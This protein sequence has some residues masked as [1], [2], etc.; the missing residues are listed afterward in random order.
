MLVSHG[1]CKPF[2]GAA[3]YVTGSGLFNSLALLW[4]LLQSV[5]IMHNY[6]AQEMVDCVS[7]MSVH[8]NVVCML[9]LHYSQYSGNVD[10]GLVFTVYTL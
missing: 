5:C 4:Y 2:L 9:L 3:N 8:Y 7:H 6:G 10:C 1:V